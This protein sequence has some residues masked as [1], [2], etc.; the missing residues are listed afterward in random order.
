MLWPTT[1]ALLA[2]LGPALAAQEPPRCKAI[3]NAPSWPPDTAW[4]ALSNAVSGRLLKPPPPAAPCHQGP[5][6]NAQRCSAVRNGWGTADWHIAHPT[7]VMWQNWANYSCPLEGQRC[8]GTG[9]PVYVVAAKT[10]EDVSAAVRF[11][12]AMNVRM[13]IKSTGHDFLG[14]SIQPNSLS[15]YT[16]GLKGIRWFDTSFSP[17]GCAR[18]I[19]GPAVTV[20]AGSLWSE[21]Y[22]S[23]R[24]KGNVN[25]VGGYRGSVS[26]GGYIGNGGHGELSA[27][28]GMAADMV[29]EID[30][31]T[32]SGEIITANECQNQDYFWAMRGGGASTYGVALTFTL[33][34][35]RSGPTAKYTGFVGGWNEL[36]AL[37]RQWTK[38]AAVGAG[39]YINGYP[40]RGTGRLSVSVYLGNATSA[41]LRSIVAPVM[42][43]LRTLDRGLGNGTEEDGEWVE[44]ASVGRYTDHDTYEDAMGAPNDVEAIN[45]ESP[46]T[47]QNKLLASWLWGPTELSSP[48]L[49]NA[50]R[51]AFDAD[52]EIMTD[53]VF[54]VGTA[55]PPFI[56]GGGNAVNPAFRTSVL[57]P[58]S[59][60]HWSGTDA[61]ELE[62]RRAQQARFGASLRSLS[63]AGGTY[64]S[65]ADPDTPGWQTAFWGANYERLFAIKQK[66]DPRGVLYCRACVGSELWTDVNGVL[67]RK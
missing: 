56:R 54:G 31:V 2:L 3:P 55:N 39:G 50:L 52:T 45:A 7:S 29:L 16:Q 18:P 41:A 44:P 8:D 15:I 21:I 13:N 9:Y 51:G 64:A 17:K 43:N 46:G 6:Y 11:A 24:A 27:K 33:Q 48:K 23:A 58:A 14:R 19:N 20:G 34:A 65:E 57:R 10:A 30:L 62:K 40:A 63:P 12:G 37:H 28:Y 26:V 47:G 59:E 42:A 22:A 49:V 67:C 53:A 61:R 38:F 5:S 60:I 25:V 4:A 36:A 66:V 1:L 35:V 32:P